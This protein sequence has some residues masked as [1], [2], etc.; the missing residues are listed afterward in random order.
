MNL[1]N[2]CSRLDKTTIIVCVLFVIVIVLLILN[3]Q[4]SNQIYAQ[5]KQT[6]DTLK[7]ENFDS[8]TVSKSKPKLVLYYTNW[9]GYSKMFLPEWEKLKKS[10][11]KDILVLEEVDCEKNKEKCTQVP[12]YPTVLLYTSSGKVVQFEKNKEGKMYSRNVEGLIRFI[13]D[14]KKDL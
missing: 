11:N 9:C 14:N 4:K 1:S 2:L 12:G 3:R 6:A 8:K 13:S 7:P 10:P 5:E